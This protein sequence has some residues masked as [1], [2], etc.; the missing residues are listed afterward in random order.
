MVDTR[1]S[2]MILQSN[3]AAMISELERLDEAGEIEKDSWE[4]TGCSH[5]G[6]GYVGHLSFLAI[7]DDGEPTKVFS[8]IMSMVDCIQEH[9]VLDSSDYSER[10]Y[11]AQLESIEANAPELDEDTL[12]GPLSPDETTKH[13]EDWRSSVFGWLWDNLQERAFEGYDRTY[14]EPDCVLEACIAL[15]YHTEEED[16]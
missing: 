10:E 11:A 3:S 14:I 8:H 4:I 9:C 15:G 13:G 6:F 5:W 1:D 7:D 2:D 12:P 16:D